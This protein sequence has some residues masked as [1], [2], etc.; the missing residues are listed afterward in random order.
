MLKVI[1]RGITFIELT[2]GIFLPWWLRCKYSELLFR[3]EAGKINDIIGTKKER[4]FA[5]FFHLG[6][7]YAQEGKMG[8]AIENLKRALE[9]NSDNN[10]AKDIHLLLSRCYKTEGMLDKSIDEIVIWYKKWKRPYT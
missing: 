9:A 1:K 7:V 10:K 5:I 6:R 2:L 3:L 8:L 4:D